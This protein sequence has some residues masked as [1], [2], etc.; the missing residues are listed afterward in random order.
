MAWT[1]GDYLSRVTAALGNRSDLA[2]STVSFW[3]NEAERVVWDLLPHD[4]K[5]ALAVSSTTS[6]ENTITLPTDFQALLNLSNTSAAGYDLLEAASYDDIDSAGTGIGTPTKYVR[7]ATWL[8]LWPSPD[9]AYSL[10]LRY[11]KARSDMTLTTSRPSV[12][13]R[14]QYAVYLKAR[15]LLAT[16]VQ[17]YQHAALS[18]NAFVEYLSAMPDDRALRQRSREGMRAS[19]Q[20]KAR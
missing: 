10:Q 7:Y 1:L 5:E 14:Y 16:E 9:S 8:E 15:E 13:T 11:E 6:G 17:D 20:R 2:A 19:W 4:A 18:H 12:G 3:V